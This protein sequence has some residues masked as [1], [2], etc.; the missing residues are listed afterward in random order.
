VSVSSS[1]TGSPGGTGLPA[2]PRR[3]VQGPT[4]VPA[5]DL[6]RLACIQPDPHGE[7]EIRG[8][9]RLLK[10]ARLQLDR[11]PDRLTGRTE[12]REG[13]VAGKK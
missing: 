2:Q 8:R 6:N 12:D 10:E 4:P 7:R 9:Q 13:R 1:W 5:L 3:E 11:R